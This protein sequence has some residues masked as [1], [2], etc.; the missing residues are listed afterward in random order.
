MVGDGGLLPLTCWSV[1]FRKMVVGDGIST[2]GGTT[3]DRVV[4]GGRARPRICIAV[5]QR[6]V[7]SRLGEKQRPGV[8]IK[9]SAVGL[10]SLVHYALVRM[11][12]IEKQVS[13]PA[14]IPWTSWS[15]LSFCTTSSIG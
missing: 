13:L 11:V 7:V 10:D 2:S 3:G 6:A 9:C 8:I 5:G 1:V 4:S 14:D 12:A 15:R